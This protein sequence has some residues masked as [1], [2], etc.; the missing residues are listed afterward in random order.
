MFLESPPSPMVLNALLFFNT[1]A[2]IIYLI[3]SWIVSST[4]CVLED[5]NC[6][7]G[8][9][10][11]LGSTA[12]EGFMIVTFSLFWIV[13]CGGA[14]YLAASKKLAKN[15]IDILT[16]LTPV[17]AFNALQMAVWAGGKRNSVRSALEQMPTADVKGFYSSSLVA[18]IVGASF[19]IAGSVA[20]AF[21]FYKFGNTMGGSQSAE[22]PSTA[23][24]NSTYQPSASYQNYDPQVAGDSYQTNI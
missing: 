1:A 10:H 17:M 22:E 8:L 3:P 18:M 12:A 2:A 21:M 19:L 4:Y 16:V 5:G 7:S 9:L 14:L 20:L 23:Y 11:L 13:V 24:D 6:G 15:H